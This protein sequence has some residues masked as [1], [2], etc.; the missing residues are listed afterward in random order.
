MNRKMMATE[1]NPIRRTAC[2]SQFHTSN[3]DKEVWLVG[4]MLK[5]IGLTKINLEHANLFGL[6]YSMG[7]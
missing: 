2:L 4:R 6:I 1:T 5:L 3:F 7:C